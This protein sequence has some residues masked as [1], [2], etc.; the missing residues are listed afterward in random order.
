MTAATLVLVACAL[1][2]AVFIIL[3]AYGFVLVRTE[4]EVPSYMRRRRRRPSAMPKDE[5]GPLSNLLEG[6]GRPFRGML[7]TL[8]GPARLE[9]ARRRIGA[10]GKA[11]A[12]STE[13]Y[14][15]RRAGSIILLTVIAIGAAYV[16]QYFIAVLLFA[17][18]MAWTDLHLWLLARRRAAEIERSLPD[19]LD[20]LAVT[21]SA[22]L[23]FRRALDRVT[24]N[25][26]G[27]LVE[28]FNVAI[29]QM[30]LGTPRREAFRQLRDRNRAHSLN[31]FLTAIL[32]AEELG[33]PLTDALLGIA[34]DM[35]QNTRQ[36]ARRQAA[37]AAPRIQLV[38]V[39]FM[40]PGA[41][42]LFLGALFI[43]VT[44]RGGFSVFG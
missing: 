8:L 24:E 12:L 9:R 2:A 32:Q 4:P 16:G 22:G 13:Q 26:S 21:V 14:L 29:H 37:R 25:M 23:G 42:I 28:E 3:F 43:A 17:F 1:A 33:A 27:P 11:S 18:G 30:E 35:R 31:Q 34:N 10:A 38:V 36:L 19:F 15:A 44:S 41:L 40:V 20:V 5:A 7:G 39:F 6:I